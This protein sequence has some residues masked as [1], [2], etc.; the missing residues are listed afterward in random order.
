MDLKFAILIPY[1]DLFPEEQRKAQLEQL[2]NY[3]GSYPDFN[4]FIIII[5][6]Q[7]YPTEKFNRG[8]VLNCGA[9]WITESPE[10]IQYIITHDCDMIPNAPLFKHYFTVADARKN[11]NLIPITQNHINAY[12]NAKFDVGGIAGLVFE[13]FL[14]CNG[15]P[16]SF[17]GWGG[18]D[19]CLRKR[20]ERQEIAC[21][22]LDSKCEEYSSFDYTSLDV[23]RRR[24][25]LTKMGHLHA[26]NLFNHTRG[27]Q[28]DEDIV[29]WRNDGIEQ[30]QL[31]V[32]LTQPAIRWSLKNGVQCVQLKLN[33][34]NA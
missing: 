28:M 30:I 15:F 23:H 20:L 18:E 29:R 14:K 27:K 33:L 21:D 17:F 7:V 24:R 10:K 11:T 22:L 34:L 1:G 6:E 31:H 26:R 5:C 4:Q 3:F 9:K 25:N 2:L 19:N 16:N 32:F 8:M 12:G 13:D